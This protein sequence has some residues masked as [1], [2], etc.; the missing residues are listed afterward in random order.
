MLCCAYCLTFSLSDLANQ[1]W[2]NLAPLPYTERGAAGQ[3]WR[4]TEYIRVVRLFAPGAH[5]LKSCNRV[6]IVPL[7]RIV[8]LIS[9]Y[10]AL[11]LSSR[12][13]SLV[14]SRSL[15]F[16]GEFLSVARIVSSLSRAS[17]SLRVS[18]LLRRA[19]YLSSLRC[20]YRSVSVSRIV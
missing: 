14:P 4:L 17:P 11:S 5:Y 16:A 7:S 2:K 13:V 6:E 20:V 8:L 15:V 9:S 18:S 12:I 19:Y 1:N 10:I 3:I